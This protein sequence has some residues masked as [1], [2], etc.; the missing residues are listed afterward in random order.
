MD[1]AID[2]TA[3]RQSCLIKQGG[4]DDLTVKFFSP[5]PVLDGKYWTR[6][7]PASWFAYFQKTAVGSSP[8]PAKISFSPDP[9]R[10]SPVRTHLCKEGRSQ[11][12]SRSERER[13]RGMQGVMEWILDFW[14]PDSSCPEQDPD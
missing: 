7:S 2:N 8:N 9:V 11:N 12:I 6:S 14:D 1:A 5:S 13:I 4:R 10:L 3:S